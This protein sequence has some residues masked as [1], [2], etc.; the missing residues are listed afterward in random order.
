MLSDIRAVIATL[1][2][3]V[4]LLL[5]SFGLVATYRTTQQQQA[6]AL[7]ADLAKQTAPPASGDRPVM[8]IETPADAHRA[9]PAVDP[10][11]ET[12]A[13]TPVAE[14]EPPAPPQAPPPAEPPIGGPLAT[15]PETSRSVAAKNAAQIDTPALQRA[16]AAKAR[17]AR[18]ARVV[19]ERKA[20][21]RRAA[22]TRRARQKET[23]AFGSKSFGSF[24]GT[25]TAPTSGQ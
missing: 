1:M 9:P 7:Q 8:I 25:F 19:R 15:A 23:P 6:G 16:A 4:G 20:A 13:A 10:P 22:Q 14:P 5:I 24:G 18:A 12:V 17:K 11:V 2:A 3:A 21:A